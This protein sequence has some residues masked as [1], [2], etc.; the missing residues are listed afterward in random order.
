MDK[1]RLEAMSRLG[2]AASEAGESLRK[3]TLAMKKLK[4]RKSLYKQWQQ[5]YKYHG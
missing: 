3:V 5:P 4:K 1:D 2:I